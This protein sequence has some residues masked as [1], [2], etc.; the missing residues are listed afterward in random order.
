MYGI[1]IELPGLGHSTDVR[2]ICMQIQCAYIIA[3][4]PHTYIIIAMHTL[5]FDNSIYISIPY[6]M[7]AFFLLLVLH[8]QTTFFLCPVEAT[9]TGGDITLKTVKDATWNACA[10]WYHLAI[11][12]DVDE[13]TIK[14]SIGPCYVHTI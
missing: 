13:G 14:V 1:Y 2:C 4:L 12:L 3:N 11:N 10:K 9:A 5:C 6:Y 8:Y 7:Y